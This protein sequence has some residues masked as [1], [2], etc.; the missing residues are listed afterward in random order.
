[1]HRRRFVRAAGIAAV[2]V[3]LAGCPAT[4]GDGGNRATDISGPEE[5][6]VVESMGRTAPE[7]QGPFEDSVEDVPPQ[8]A[9]ELTFDGLIFQRAGE[10]G[11]VIAGDLTNTGDQPLGLVVIQSVIY[12]RDQDTEQV[13]ESE[14]SETER[15]GLDAGETWN[16]ATL[17]RSEP[18]FEIDYY[19]VRALANFE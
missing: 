19:T 14:E 1:M 11:L 2:S 6:D 9:E 18:E 17:F 7:A 8:D 5:A 10:R 12:N 13:V 15:N 16:W 3:G 4:S